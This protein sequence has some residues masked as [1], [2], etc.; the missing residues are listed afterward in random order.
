MHRLRLKFGRG[1]KLKFLSHLDLMRL[2]E[3]ALRRAGMP[4]A[5]SEGFSPHPKISLAAPLP[6]GVTSQAEVMDIFLGR[7]VTPGFFIQ[8]VAP[9]LPE[10]MTI[11]DI[12]PVSIQAPS[13]QSRVRQAEY[14]VEVRT[15]RSVAQ[16]EAGIASI[17][18]MEQLAWHHARDTG[19]K[20]YD[21]RTL[22]DDLWLVC[23]TQ[24]GCKIGMRLRCGPL[25][26][27]RPEQVVKALGIDEV[28]VS[29]ERTK[30]I[31]D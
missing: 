29:I 20:Y 13:L 14:V 18:G 24:T 2:W 8:K 25:G 10:G 16:M 19:E 31:F 28:P 17:M 11:L 23:D 21:L 27:G 1:N 22:I 5:Y 3:R 30:L 12:S 6:V 4:P 9:Q 7:R 26:S 15:G